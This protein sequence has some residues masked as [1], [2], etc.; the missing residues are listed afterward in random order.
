MKNRL[1]IS[2]EI[3]ESSDRDQSWI[4]EDN[5]ASPD[6]APESANMDFIGGQFKK[7]DVFIDAKALSRDE[8][9]ALLLPHRH[10]GS[11]I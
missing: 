2:L 11:K 6:E 3:S 7:G 5:A 8:H 1:T 10:P 4:R 9:L